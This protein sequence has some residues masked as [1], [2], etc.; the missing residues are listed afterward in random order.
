MSLIISGI[1]GI[2][3]IS[4]G[5]LGVS[6]SPPKA[7]AS[8]SCPARRT[9]IVLSTGAMCFACVFKCVCAEGSCLYIVIGFNTLEM[10]NLR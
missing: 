7:G 5:S 6:L 4:Y 8:L 3:W 1:A 9:M 2:M 10:S